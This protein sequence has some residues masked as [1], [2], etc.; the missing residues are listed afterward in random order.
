MTKLTE[1]DLE[2]KKFER[3]GTTSEELNQLRTKIFNALDA[4]EIQERTKNRLLK[5][6]YQTASLKG[7]FFIRAMERNTKE[8]P[9]NEE[10]E[11]K[12][13]E[14]QEDE[15]YEESYEESYSYEEDEPEEDEEEDKDES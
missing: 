5:D 2:L 9:K 10:E 11:A 1:L 15:S 6:L 3:V 4:G 14:E 12:R 7:I 8:L 13:I